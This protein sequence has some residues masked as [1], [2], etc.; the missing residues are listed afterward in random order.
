M[1]KVKNIAL[2]A[3]TLWLQTNYIYVLAQ[4]QNLVP[5]HSF[6]DLT[7]GC[8]PDI[9]NNLINYTLNWYRPNSIGSPDYFHNC[10][11]SNIGSM[12]QPEN[13][14]GFQLPK[15]GDAY[16]GI[17]NY[18]YISNQKEYLG[19]QLLLPLQANKKYYFE[20]HVS[21]AELSNMVCHNIGAYFSASLLWCNCNEINS[22]IPQVENILINQSLNNKTEWIKVS[23]DFIAMG[24]EE[25]LTIGNFRNNN[26]SEVDSLEFPLNLNGPSYYYIDDVFLYDYEAW[27]AWQDS[28]NNN[29]VPINP[30]EFKIPNAF[31]P[32]ADGI[33]DF[34]VIQGIEECPN[35]ELFIYNRWGE[36]VYYKEKY[37]NTFSGYSNTSLSPS[38][39]RDVQRTKPLVEGTYYYV[40][41]TGKENESYNGFLELRR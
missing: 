6:E 4:P 40:F 41:R 24:N 1:I 17:Y 31:S 26:N 19:A 29:P 37:D 20:M 30:V 32:N 38:S 12:G 39:K 16:A 15:T 23:G 13:A 8:P 35:N 33:N 25:Y 5:N 28:L 14:F 11:G 27:Q 21:L 34:F 36:L 22:V 7:S 3:A 18:V 2:F 9:Q 10:N